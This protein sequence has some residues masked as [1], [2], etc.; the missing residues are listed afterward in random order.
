MYFWSTISKPWYHRPCLTAFWK[1]IFCRIM[2]RFW[3]LWS[4][5]YIIGKEGQDF[6]QT[7]SHDTLSIKRN[8]NVIVKLSTIFS[9][10]VFPC[11]V[12]R[13]Y[14]PWMIYQYSKPPMFF[15]PTSLCFESSQ[16]QTTIW[17]TAKHGFL[18]SLSQFQ[19]QNY[20]HLRES[21]SV[22]FQCCSIMGICII[23]AKSFGNQPSKNCMEKR[24]PIISSIMAHEPTKKKNA[25]GVWFQQFPHWEQ[26]FPCHQDEPLCFSSFF[27]A[28]NLLCWFGRYFSALSGRNALCQRSAF[29]SHGFLGRLSQDLPRF[30]TS[31]VVQNIFHQQY[32]V[33]LGS[34]LPS[35]V[36][37]DCQERSP[38]WTVLTDSDQKSH[39][40]QFWSP[41][42]DGFPIC[43]QKG[44][45]S[46]RFLQRHLSTRIPLI[47]RVQ[48][49]FTGSHFREPTP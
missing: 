11:E 26:G 37:D 47:V 8:R 12:E 45:Y 40:M 13:L 19:K 20:S 28:A 21:N 1:A 42:L 39:F 34:T 48:T 23:S 27:Y 43:L 32:E 3:K 14:D 7:H 41:E 29:P 46:E 22:F 16:I 4:M 9:P 24:L 6:A 35:E 44:N 49:S 31:Q 36:R 2:R 38:G 10:W 25:F 18:C 33:F 17:F 30:H 15:I 5:S